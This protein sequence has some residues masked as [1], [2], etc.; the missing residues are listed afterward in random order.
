MTPANC[1]RQLIIH[2]RFRFTICLHSFAPLITPY[3]SHGVDVN[4]DAEEQAG[5]TSASTKPAGGDI[6]E[7]GVAMDHTGNM[8]VEALRQGQ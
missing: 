3:T 4:S 2:N 6:L 1:S 8:P 7:V 5:Y